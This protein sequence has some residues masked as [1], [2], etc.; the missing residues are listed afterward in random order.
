MVNPFDRSTGGGISAN[1]RKGKTAED[2]VEAEIRAKGH[3][4][5]RIHEGADFEVEIPGEPGMYLVEV[6]TGGATLT[7]S[8]RALKNKVEAGRHRVYYDYIIRRM[9]NP[10]WY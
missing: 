5:T 10:S 7:Q 9:G 4:P 8:Q 3:M 2:V 1:N 6:K